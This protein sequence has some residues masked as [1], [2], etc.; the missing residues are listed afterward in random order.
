MP[1]VTIGF[2]YRNADELQ[3]SRHPK[4]DKHIQQK[5]QLSSQQVHPLDILSEVSAKSEK[6]PR[7]YGVDVFHPSCV[8]A[9]L[10]PKF[11][12]LPSYSKCL[13][14]LEIHRE[15]TVFLKSSGFPHPVH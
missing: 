7:D 12:V 13:A 6:W 3:G 10:V 9:L 5:Q 14:S 8:D 1:T 2:F 15:A 4:A 11:Y